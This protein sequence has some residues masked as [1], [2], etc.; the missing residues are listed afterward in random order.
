MIWWIEFPFTVSDWSLNIW[1]VIRDQALIMPSGDVETGHWRIVSFHCEASW[2]FI[3]TQLIPGQTFSPSPKSPTSDRNCYHFTT[4]LPTCYL[5][6]HSDGYS[7]QSFTPIRANQSVWKPCLS[8][9]WK[10]CQ[11]FLPFAVYLDESAILTMSLCRDILL[12]YVSGFK[13]VAIFKDN[14]FAIV[15]LFNG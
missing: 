13:Y 11:N 2:S 1:V 14:Q 4:H 3:D 9:A 8:K 12:I 5:C 7:T 10:P 15:V 6:Q